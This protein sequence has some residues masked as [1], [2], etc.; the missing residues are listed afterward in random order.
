MCRRGYKSVVQLCCRTFSDIF[1]PCGC[2][3]QH[4]ACVCDFVGV[5]RALFPDGACST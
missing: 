5:R 2:E 3:R 1:L 4:L